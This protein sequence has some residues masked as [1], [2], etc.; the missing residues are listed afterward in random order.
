MIPSQ[1]RFKG[2]VVR[3]EII[4]H[5][6]IRE[7]LDSVGPC[8]SCGIV[9]SLGR[10]SAVYWKLLL[11]SEPMFLYLLFFLSKLE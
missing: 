8:I 11:M 1:F 2:S 10:N 6:S 9:T 5:F 3:S 7:T 4:S